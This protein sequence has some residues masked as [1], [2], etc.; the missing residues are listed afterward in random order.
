MQQ[1]K[2]QMGEIIFQLPI[3]NH[4]DCDQILITIGKFNC[5]LNI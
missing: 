5:D 1:A 4:A 2:N 3:I